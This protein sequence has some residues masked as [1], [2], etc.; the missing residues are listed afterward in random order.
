MT[1]DAPERRFRG[2]GVSGG[3]AIGPVVVLREKA[4][5]Q[6]AFAGVEE[7]RRAFRAAIAEAAG[8]IDRL[9]ASEDELAGEILEF[10]LALLGDEDLL[11]PVLRAIADG[12]A[13]DAA[14]ASTMDAE[15]ADYRKG[16][17]DT[18]A[19]RAADLADLKSR[20]LRAVQEPSAAAELPDGAILIA[21]ELTP[22]TFL[23]LDWTGIGGAAT[24]GG[25]PT[26]HVA[27]L[28]R[29]RGVN[30]IVGLSAEF[31]AFED[32]APAILDAPEGVVIAG[33]SA[34]TLAAA[35]ARLSAA[36]HDD[37]AIEAL[38]RKPAMTPRGE[39]VQVLVNI[40]EPDRLDSIPPEICDGVGLTRTEFLFRHGQ[41]TEE[42]QFAFYARLISWAQGRPVTI[43]TLDAGGDKP[44]PG[45]TF[46]GEANPFL[47]VRGLRLSL[48]K[49]DI[50]RTQLRALAR[51]AALGPVKVMVPMV[52]VP[53]ELTTA[54][55]MMLD[56]IAALQRAG[57]PCATP[58]LGMMIEVPAAA[59]TAAA[60]NADFYSIGSNDLIQYA[61][62]SARDNAALAPLA[63]PLN[64]AVLELIARTVAAARHRNVEVSLCGDM[65]STPHLIAP[66]LATGLRSLSC[67]PAQIGAV[68]LAISRTAPE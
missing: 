41:P 21:A 6:R 39:R 59:L 23:D 29:S 49:P 55:E 63:D 12:E 40:D 27:I 34:A 1:E 24:L 20:V 7:E 17:D 18:L 61:T 46:D 68:K 37:R 10:Q 16:G 36:S 32:G 47:G 67:A 13:W 60:F 53:A 8:Q 65:A 30:L 57:M 45:I 43:R 9:I 48:A 35:T 51:A 15:I 19:A 26:S 14:W 66:L 22:S 56:E 62:A 54:R 25:S 4:A 31:D 50:F 58:P 33:P 5:A 11:A 42:A 52:T 28:A 38:I 3:I 64:P 2:I 44:I